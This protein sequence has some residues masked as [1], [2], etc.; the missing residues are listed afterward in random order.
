MTVMRLF[1]FGFALVFILISCDKDDNKNGGTSC[2][3]QVIINN[4]LYENAPNDELTFVSIEIIEDCL[5]IK[6]TSSG[7]DGSSWEVKLIASEDIAESFPPQRF[8]RLS[9]KN[10]EVCDAVIT[11]EISFGITELRTDGNQLL[12]NISDWEDPL[13]YEY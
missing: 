11:K 6:F 8:L 1:I 3:E 7:C 13:L 4:E 5:K 12:L 10:E 2:D 9:L